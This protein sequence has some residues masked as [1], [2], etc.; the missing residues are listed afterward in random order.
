[1]ELLA[2]ARFQMGDGTA[3]DGKRVLR[4]ES[5]AEMKRPQVRID[6]FND[7]IGLAWMLRDVDGVRLASHGGGTTGQVSLLEMAPER[8]FALALVTNCDEGGLLVDAARK[9]ALALY[10]G[11]D[12]KEPAPIETAEE[13]LQE[14]AGRYMRPFADVELVVEGGRLVG[15]MIFKQ[16]FPSQNVP[17]PPPTTPIPCAPYAADRL[18]VTDGSFKHS[19][20]EMIRQEDGTV[21]WCRMGRLFKRVEA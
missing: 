9:R 10:L 21:G 19:R 6:S 7:A 20:L 8:Q 16:G 1:M 18:I 15:T 17:P 14:Y 3:V 13:T 4:A 2:Y 5:M 11:L 12:E